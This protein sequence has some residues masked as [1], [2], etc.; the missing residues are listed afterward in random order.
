[1]KK[2]FLWGVLCLFFG[3]IQQGYSQS[4]LF[5]SYDAAGNQTSR[6]YCASNCIIRQN[7][8]INNE[9]DAKPEV[10]SESIADT[11]DEDIVMFPNPTNGRLQLQ[12]GNDLK[13]KL[14]EITLINYMGA[15]IKKIDVTKDQKTVLDISSFASGVYIAKFSF[16]DRSSL[17]RKILKN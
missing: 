9:E 17:S 6:R 5:I 14:Q 15:V 11:I 8:S 3:T 16:S 1:M 12:W 7:K 4:K 13:G 2:L 10:G